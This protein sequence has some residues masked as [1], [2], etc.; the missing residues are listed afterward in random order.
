MG[1]GCAYGFS[2]ADSDLLN[3]DESS[4]ERKCGCLM[5]G[6]G[7]LNGLVVGEDLFGR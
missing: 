3:A 7:T 6:I 4:I 1:Y 5:V 2:N